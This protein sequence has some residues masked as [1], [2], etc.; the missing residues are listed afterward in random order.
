MVIG[1]RRAVIFSNG[2]YRHAAG[3]LS[4]LSSEDYLICADGALARLRELELVPDL[5]VGDMDSA[6]ASLVDQ[7][8]AQ[9]VEILRVPAEKDFTDTEM[10]LREAVGR[11]YAQVLV[12]GAWGGRIDHSLGNL[13]LFPP[14]IDAGTNVTLSDGSTDA[15]YVKEE[16]Q[17]DGCLGRIVSLLPLTPVVKGVTID[18]FQYPLQG[19]TLRWGKT[20]GVSNIAISDKIS[21]HLSE[22]MLLAVLTDILADC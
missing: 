20:L 6:S 7:A 1:L 4:R 5:V 22:G 12:L 9:G 13:L 17:L 2:E 3:V 8:A 11:G 16:L 10:A 18:G 14:F 19:A 21:I 15:Y